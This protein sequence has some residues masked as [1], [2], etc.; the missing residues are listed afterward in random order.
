M[1]IKPIQPR[2]YLN[3]LE[4]R[5]NEFFNLT[6][7]LNNYKDNIEEF[8]KQHKEHIY[9]G[10][11]IIYS[12][13]HKIT[14][15]ENITYDNHKI[16]IKINFD[17]TDLATNAGRYNFIYKINDDTEVTI[18]KRSKKPLQITEFKY[19]YYSDI[20]FQPFAL[21]WFD[22][23]MKIWCAVKKAEY[24]KFNLI[25]EGSYKVSDNK[26]TTELTVYECDSQYKIQK[27]T[28]S[29][30]NVFADIYFTKETKLPYIPIN[31]PL[32]K[33]KLNIYEVY[34]NFDD[35]ESLLR[36][37]IEMNINNGMNLKLTDIK[38]RSINNKVV[39]KFEDNEFTYL[40]VN[41]VVFTNKKT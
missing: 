30:P 34:F 21:N 4:Q 31:K 32:D 38:Y 18:I 9:N 8:F 39:Y 26:I 22:Y 12:R 5:L 14:D 27:A 23:L 7:L 17:V 40:L 33:I 10:S 13:N 20:K 24:T 2:E 25:S 29:N 6:E 28:F 41:K 15:V 19:A 16:T 3:I 35:I 36:E 1:K 37:V 11:V